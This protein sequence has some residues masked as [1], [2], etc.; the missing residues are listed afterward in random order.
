MPGPRL[1][2]RRWPKISI[3]QY[4]PRGTRRAPRGASRGEGNYFLG[5]PKGHWLRGVKMEGAG[6]GGA[7][8]VVVV[9]KSA[10]HHRAGT[11]VS[12]S[13]PL[14]EIPTNNG[15]NHDYHMGLF[16]PRYPISFG[17]NGNQKE[18]QKEDRCII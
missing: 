6:G 4:R 18:D 14:T 11:L 9:S 16:F 12:D 13:I 15:F 7:S 8:L 17:G 5:E 10:L 1:T 2:C 3:L